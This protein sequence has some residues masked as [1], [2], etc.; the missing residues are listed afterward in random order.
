MQSFYEAFSLPLLLA[1]FLHIVIT[2]LLLCLQASLS[3]AVTFQ[4]SVF[5]RSA[6]RS[7]LHTSLKR[8][9]GRPVGIFPVASSPY[10]RSFGRRPSFIR[11]TCPSHRMR[12]CFKRVYKLGISASLVLSISPMYPMRQTNGGGTTPIWLGLPSLRR[13]VAV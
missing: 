7:R 5:M 3:V 9:W 12:L 11:V 1:V 4:E 13:A 10:K 8:S 2:P 6:W